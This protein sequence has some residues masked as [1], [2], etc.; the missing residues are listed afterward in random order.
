MVQQ[1]TI[2]ALGR[3]CWYPRLLQ[4]HSEGCA[5][6]NVLHEH[7]GGWAGIEKYYRSTREAVLVQQS[8]IG[9]L[10]RLF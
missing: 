6:T 9:A 8:I 5:G 2:G 1:S 10:G 4:E 7:W 3:L